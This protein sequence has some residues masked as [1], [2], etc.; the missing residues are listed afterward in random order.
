[1]LLEMLLICPILP[2]FGW[3][4]LK[5][6]EI[7]GCRYVARP[8]GWCP[9][10]PLADSWLVIVL[11]WS[12]TGAWPRFLFSGWLAGVWRLVS[13]LVLVFPLAGWRLVPSF[14]FSFFSL[15]KLCL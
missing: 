12:V 5:L 8:P 11:S 1:M 9:S 14:W 10:E 6:T 15:T 3:N 13:G 2:D 7:A 4:C